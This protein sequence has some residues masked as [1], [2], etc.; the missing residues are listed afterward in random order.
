[1]RWLSQLDAWGRT[2]DARYMGWLDRHVA[3]S[4]IPAVAA[5]ISIGFPLLGLLAIL[6]LLVSALS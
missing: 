4:F 6:Y 3:P 2:V 1:M 5:G